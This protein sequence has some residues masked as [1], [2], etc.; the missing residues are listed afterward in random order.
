MIIIE[1][2]ERNLQ[3]PKKKVTF[4]K[5]EFD[6]D[7]EWV[8]IEEAITMVGEDTAVNIQTN[9]KKSLPDAALISIELSKEKREG[10]GEFGL[11]MKSGDVPVCAMLKNATT[12][13]PMF[14]GMIMKLLEFT[15]MP[16][17]CP[18]PVVSGSIVMLV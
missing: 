5:V 4:E 15:N 14:K 11:F 2:I 8:V 1:L 12:Q 17:Q 6:S 7:P 16:Y 13:H 10:Q 18:L 9:I 3:V